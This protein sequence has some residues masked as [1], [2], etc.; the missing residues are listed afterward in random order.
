MR[1][2]RLPAA[3]DPGHTRALLSPSSRAPSSPWLWL[4]LLVVAGAVLRFAWLADA[5]GL[6]FF[7]APR[8]DD[9]VYDAGAARIAGGD[10]LLDG[11]SL[12]F[13]P[14]YF[15]V[16]GTL[17][18][19]FGRGVWVPRILHAALGTALIVVVYLTGKRLTTPRWA[20]LPAAL[21]AF[22]GPLLFFEALILPE[23]LQ[24]LV[25]AG[26][27][28]AALVAADGEGD[29]RRA[30]LRWLPVGLLL[31][32][33]VALRP[34]ALLLLGPLAWFVWARPRRWA[35]LGAVLGG[36][37]L[38]L[39]PLVARNV[40]ATGDPS[41]SG[42]AGINAF[43]G[44]GP[45]ASGLFRVPPEVPRASS[46][47][48]QIEGFHAAAEA[49][50]GHRLTPS[51][52]DRFWLGRTL[53][54]AAAHPLDAAWLLAR[55]VRFFWNDREVSALVRY[56]FTRTLSPVLGAPLV[57]FG[58]F[59]PLALV[60][61][62]LALRRG[63]ERSARLA[64]GFVLAGTL[65]VVLF[66]VQDRYRI[67]F[68]PAFAVTATLGAK[69]LLDA[70]RARARRRVALGLAALAAGLLLAFPPLRFR[71]HPEREFAE[72]AAQYEDLGDLAEAE[73]A[74]RRAV[75]AS[76]VHLPALLGRARLLA[77]MRPAEAPEAFRR[78]LAEAER[79]GDA[80]S[81]QQARDALRPR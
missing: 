20:L 48:G 69:E 18:A 63:A 66:F 11:V 52:S 32:L 65:S 31:G 46:P 37:L 70:L 62:L 39:S 74:W 28:L 41:F 72:L 7:W 61:C 10:V 19:L 30:A 1:G 43:I 33:A 25:H 71:A 56:D 40:L 59:A 79:Q 15:Y 35:A 49:A 3:R 22:D 77:R 34:N 29:A 27:L 16:L 14:P 58:L 64:A 68:V 38:A 51:E 6:P 12:R 45:G 73:R 24:A 42:T 50:L 57:R 60:G 54:H 8:T 23:T 67:P 2:S 44:N 9:F 76:P 36:L 13:G 75:E 53:A 47:E 55:K 4:G 81:A 80:A 5:S 26:L 17:Y 78:A 21:V